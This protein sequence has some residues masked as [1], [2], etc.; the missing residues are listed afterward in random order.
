[1]CVLFVVDAVFFLFYQSRVAM[2][3]PF[4]PIEMC[5]SVIVS[6]KGASRLNI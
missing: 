1:M 4:S 6:L 2:I 3:L 5:M